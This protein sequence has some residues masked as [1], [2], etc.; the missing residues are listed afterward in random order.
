MNIISTIIILLVSLSASGEDAQYAF[1][2]FRSDNVTVIP[3]PIILLFN[4][5]GTVKN[6]QLFGV[7]WYEYSIIDGKSVDFVSEERGKINDRRKSSE[8]KGEICDLYGIIFNGKGR[9]IETPNFAKELYGDKLKMNNENSIELQKQDY[10]G[11][12]SKLA[13]SKFYEIDATEAGF[14]QLEKLKTKKIIFAKKD[15]AV[16]YIRL[17]S[18]DSFINLILLDKTKAIA[19]AFK[20]G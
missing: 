2:G 20:D 15:N 1:S 19:D 13:E 18:Q 3:Q 5:K 4:S 17:L 9:E 14:I 11:T 10:I 7:G 12:L 8:S 16:I 6:A